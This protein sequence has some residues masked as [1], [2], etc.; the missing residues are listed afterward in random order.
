MLVVV[1]VMVVML[2][3]FALA[4]CRRTPLGGSLSLGFSG[5]SFGRRNPFGF[6]GCCGGGGLAVLFVVFVLNN[7]FNHCLGLLL[8]VFIIQMGLAFP[9]WALK[10]VFIHTF[11]TCEGRRGSRNMLCM[12]LY[13]YYGYVAVLHLEPFTA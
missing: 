7:L 12:L 5:G 3:L 4:C 11:W 2:G 10:F 8:D 1:M 6:F 13:I 9:V